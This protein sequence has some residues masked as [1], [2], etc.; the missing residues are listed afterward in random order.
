MR[1]KPTKTLIPISSPVTGQKKIM[2]VDDDPHIRWSL[3]KVLR[4]EGYEVVLA[5]DGQEGVEK[6]RAEHI[7]LLLLDVSLPDIGGWDVFGTVSSLNPLVPIII[8][9]ARDEQRDLAVLSG[10]AALIGKPF[11]VPKLI[12]IIGEMLVES[13]EMHLKR[14]VGLHGDLRQVQPLRSVSP[15]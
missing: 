15:K 4:A 12:L 6:F 1:P 10:V 8:I 2:V 11:D 13:P 3:Q 5:A 7:D 9:T 14:L